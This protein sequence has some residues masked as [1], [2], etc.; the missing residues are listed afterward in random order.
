MR[1]GNYTY[2]SLFR[3]NKLAGS[4][5]II[6]ILNNISISMYALSVAQYMCSAIPALNIKLIAIVVLTVITVLNLFG[7][8]NA[9][10]L[11]GVL[12]ACLPAAL[13]IFCGFGIIKV[14]PQAYLSGKGMFTGGAM[15]FCSAAALLTFATSGAQ[16][17]INFSAEAKN[18]T[19]DMPDHYDR[20]HSGSCSSVRFHDYC[21]Q[22]YS[23]SR[24]GC[25]SA[26]F[27]SCR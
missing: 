21:R 11:Q 19:G 22:R 20:F 18:P 15:G 23:A 12:V 2:I 13:V 5:L 26:P 10:K 3:G 27:I 16:V 1:G 4:Y 7:V 9:A 25:K 6:H 17:I 8:E 14:D 24:C